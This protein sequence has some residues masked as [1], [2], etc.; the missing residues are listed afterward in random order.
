MDMQPL[1]SKYLIGE[2]FA[3]S[4]TGLVQRGRDAAGDEVVV[5]T[6]HAELIQ[7]PQVYAAMLQLWPVFH[8]LRGPNLVTVREMVTEGDT[9]ALVMD[10]VPGVDLAGHLHENGPLLP[11]EIARIGAD[12]A[13]ALAR[14][15]GLNI[16]H[17]D[18]KPSNVLMEG[19]QRVPRIGDFQVA[20]T[21]LGTRGLSREQSVPYAAPELLQG[22]WPTGASDVYSLG[23]LLYEMSCLVTP[24]AADAV[25]DVV[26]GHTSRH[27]GMPNGIP[28]ELWNLVLRM[29][30]KVPAN[31]PTAGDVAAA[32]RGMAERLVVLPAAERLTR[33]P[34]GIAIGAKMS[35]PA[36]PTA[37]PPPPRTKGKP[38][39]RR[40][41]AVTAAVAVV[42][43]GIWFV[44][45]RSGESAGPPAG[46]AATASAAT[47][48]ARTTG[49]RSATPT[50]TSAG[51][52]MPE[53]VGLRLGEARDLLPASVKVENKE[54]FDP[55]A[56]DGTVT[57]Q[58]PEPGTA[59]PATVTLTVARPLV[60]VYLDAQDPANGYW[61]EAPAVVG[62]AGQTLPHSLV[63]R[64][65]RCSDPES[66]EYALSRGYRKLVVKAGL[67]DDSADAALEVQ[68]EV[69]ADDRQVH[70]VVVRYNEIA[71]IDLDMT[72]VARLKF[73]WQP[74][75]PEDGCDTSRLAL[76][77]AALLGAAGEVP[78]SGLRPTE[79]TTTG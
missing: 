29:I 56:A 57:A 39:A 48:S 10:A 21:L 17:G 11:G 24:F 68:L 40:I 43:A 13:D 30:D 50:Q 70:S 71:A 79:T 6:I 53:L 46:E 41:V 51:R 63:D 31:R 1:R 75:T 76:G 27:P 19:P 66:V 35:V 55:Q 54:V 16:V 26:F 58:D 59:M 60:K 9:M 22:G 61:D 28:E 15:H 12:L 4:G 78:T 37:F 5:K 3:R 44:S 52:S 14:A 73:L 64:I 34:A 74:T 67:T 8:G 72:G 42:G 38:V 65:S 69:F 7:N 25:R 77:E 47:S 49:A 32:L 18:L 33:P 2:P 62:V 45:G 23:V 20:W 36:M